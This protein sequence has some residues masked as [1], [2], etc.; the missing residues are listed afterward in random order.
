MLVFRYRAK[1]LL[2]SFKNPGYKEEC[3]WRIVATVHKKSEKIHYRN[4][5]FGITPYVKLNLSRRDDLPSF[6]LPL[7]ALWVGPNSPTKK[8]TR[9]VEMLL[10][11]KGVEVEL[12]YSNTDY[13]A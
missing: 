12:L 11:S 4:G 2:I 6:N 10:E 1:E 9:G 13:R 8:N 5:R 7:T 3:E